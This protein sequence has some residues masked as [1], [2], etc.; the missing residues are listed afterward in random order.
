[1]QAKE[2]APVINRAALFKA[3]NGESPEIQKFHNPLSVSS[4]AEAVRCA[5]LRPNPSDSLAAP[6]TID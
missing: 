4:I 2:N 1:M 6:K 5:N 3:Q